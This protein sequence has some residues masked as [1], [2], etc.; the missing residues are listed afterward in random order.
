[1]TLVSDLAQLRQAVV[2]SL[3]SKIPNV[4]IDVHGGTFDLDE[5]KRYATLAPAIRVAVAGCGKAYRW[6]DGRWAVPVNFAAV[7]VAKDKTASDRSAIVGRDVGALML[8]TMVELAVQKNRFGLEGVRQPEN[9]TAR[10]E[11]SGKV[12][13][14][15]LALWQVVWTSEALLGEGVDE[16]IAAIAQMLAIEGDAT[17]ADQ[18]TQIYPAEATP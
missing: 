18:A 11:Y 13:A 14:I 8:A 6:G 15:G 10:N 9:V 2:D 7:C 4:D 16:T 5:V 17:P 1:M 3:K 12:D